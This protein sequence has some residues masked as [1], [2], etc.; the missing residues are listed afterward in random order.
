MG[1]RNRAQEKSQVKP[2]TIRDDNSNKEVVE[3]EAMRMLGL[4]RTVYVSGRSARSHRAGTFGSYDSDMM[5]QETIGETAKPKYKA[6]R[7]AVDSP[8]Q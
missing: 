8:S 7:Q 2:E 6:T 4:G 5:T 1:E 3:A